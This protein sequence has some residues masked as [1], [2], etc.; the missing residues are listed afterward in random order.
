MDVDTHSA[1]LK[2]RQL[3]LRLHPE[4]AVPA[5]SIF[6]RVVEIKVHSKI[7]VVSHRLPI[8]N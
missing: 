7:A 1:Q 6:S 5:V 2:I 3:V 8:V 4:G